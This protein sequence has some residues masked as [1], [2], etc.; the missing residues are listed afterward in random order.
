MI[1]GNIQMKQSILFAGAA[2]SLLFIA[3]C[4]TT[5]SR[6]YKAST[7]NI[8]AAQS[9]MKG[10]DAKVSIG[11]FSAASGVNIE[12]TCRALGALEVAPGQSPIE[13]I[14]DALQEELF[15]AGVLEEGGTSINGVIEALEFNSFGTGSWDVALKLSSKN[16]PE[17]YTVS[18][19]HEF[20]TSF[21]AINACQNV[22][23]A[24]QPT[25]AGLLN[26]AITDPNFV[27]LAGK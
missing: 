13:Y 26:E 23:D 8:M 9:A 21:S 4:E 14:E 25:V 17:G 16:L 22:I 2:A 11:N 27:K 3:G 19:H 10:S 20:K 1:W 6:P 5:S 7:E 12:P 24:F 15:T 18:T